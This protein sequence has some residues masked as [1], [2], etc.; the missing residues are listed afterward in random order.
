MESQRYVG[1]GLALRGSLTKGSRPKDFELE[2][3]GGNI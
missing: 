3:Y 2:S 1:G